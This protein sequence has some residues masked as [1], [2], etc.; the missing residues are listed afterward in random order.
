M[1]TRRRREPPAP[2]VYDL[3]VAWYRSRQRRRRERRRQLQYRPP[4]AP[5]R[6]MTEEDANA[7]QERQ[8]AARRERCRR[9]RIGD[10]ERQRGGRRTES[11]TSTSPEAFLARQRAL[12]ARR[13]AERQR[14]AD[15]DRRRVHALMTSSTGT[16]GAG[17]PVTDGDHQY[18]L[19][20]DTL[21]R[22]RQ[23]RH[24]QQQAARERD[25]AQVDGAAARRRSSSPSIYDRDVERRRQ[26][27]R[28]RMAALVSSVRRD[29]AEEAAARAPCASDPLD[30]VHRLM[31]WDARRQCRRACRTIDA[32]ADLY[33]ACPF[34]HRRR[35]APFHLWKAQT[36]HRHRHAVYEHLGRQIGAIV[37]QQQGP[38][39][40]TD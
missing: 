7:F 40:D 2:S 29:I 3:N 5:A 4:P 15:D 27:H 38:V 25:R 6:P 21:Q 37:Q 8:R 33:L 22:M 31:D 12:E 35:P 1:D 16:G 24:E 28:E 9:E 32:R 11:A 23:W 14:L 10:E 13:D 30:A 20:M 36:E 18:R 26:A 39:V 17:G 19:G 34:D